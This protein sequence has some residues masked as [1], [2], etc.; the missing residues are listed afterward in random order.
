MAERIIACE[1]LR[2]E[3]ELAMARTGRAPET[4]WLDKGLHERPQ[5]LRDAI[6]ERLAGI[7]ADCELVLL[8]MSYCGG[9]LDGVGCE[10]AA[11][12]VPRFDDCIRMLLSLAPGR[13][14]EADCRSLYFTRQWLDSERYILR[15]LE[16]YRRQY[17][18]KRGEKIMR[19]MLASYRQVRLIDTGAYDVAAYEDTAIADAKTLGLSYER[20]SGTIRVLE[21]LLRHEFDEEFCVAA[22]GEK[23]T[24]WQFI[25]I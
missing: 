20:Q 13:R 18:E 11:L 4:I 8:A 3:L 14:N 7:P 10:T 12:A 15:D 21:K 22:P 24:Q 6:L 23:L 2:D 19:T 9:A 5:V 1:M 17:G 16:Q 25:G